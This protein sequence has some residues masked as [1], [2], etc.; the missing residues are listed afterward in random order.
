MFNIKRYR[1]ERDAIMNREGVITKEEEIFIGLPK[2]KRRYEKLKEEEKA[3]LSV[4]DLIKAD[5]MLKDGFSLMDIGKYFGIYSRPALY[6]MVERK[7]PLS[8][9]VNEK[10]QKME[11]PKKQFR[12]TK[13]VAQ[14]IVRLYDGGAPTYSIAL[15][16]AVNQVAIRYVLKK[17][18]KKLD[19]NH[20]RLSHL[21]KKE[22]EAIFRYHSEGY[23][24][25]KIAAL[26]KIDAGQ[27]ERYIR[28][29]IKK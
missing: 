10:P 11:S 25:E 21:T 15:K 8:C 24:P 3:I 17:Y 28:R 18:G 16:F 26:L 5:D 23:R 22:E 6:R 19:R 13:E 12:P 7:D 27:V 1:Q 29:V 20:Q 14:E 2:F 4:R 9:V